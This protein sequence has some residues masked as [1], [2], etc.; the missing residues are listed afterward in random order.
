[1]LAEYANLGAKADP[2]DLASGIVATEILSPEPPPASPSKKRSSSTSTHTRLPPATCNVL[3]HA[4]HPSLPPSP[5]QST[6]GEQQ[7]PCTPRHA[8]GMPQQQPPLQAPLWPPLP[9]FATATAMVL[10]HA[11]AHCQWT[12]VLLPLVAWAHPHTRRLVR[13]QGRTT[14]SH[15]QPWQLQRWQ[16]S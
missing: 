14:P 5:L 13:R 4:P 11:C 6:N 9:P 8:Q 10:E 16:S 1:M 2:A 12:V 7:Q 3:T 15:Q